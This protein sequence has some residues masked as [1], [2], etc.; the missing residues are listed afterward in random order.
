M[1]AILAEI[2]W[3]GYTHRQLLDV[4]N[5]YQSNASNLLRGRITKVSIEKLQCYAHRLKMRSSIE[6]L[7]PAKPAESDGQGVQHPKTLC[8]HSSAAISYPALRLR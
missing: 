6:L 4:L 7:P 3:R 2:D 1:E 5:E 8:T